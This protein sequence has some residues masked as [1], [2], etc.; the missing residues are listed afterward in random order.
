MKKNSVNSKYSSEA[1]FLRNYD[2]N[3]FS[4]PSAAVDNVIYTIFDGALHVLLVK[5][6]NHPFMDH[7]SLVGG[8]VDLENDFNLES[9][10]KRKLEEK[11]GVK[12]PYLEQFYT[13]GNKDRDPRC[14]SITSVYFALIP[15]ENIKLQVGKGA[16]DIKWAKILKGTIKEKMAFDHSKIIQECTQRLK[17][18]VLYTCQ[19]LLF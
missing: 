10:A 2:P 17:N 3:I 9:T 12:T 5:R 16:K 18:K 6:D 1:E 11:T 19:M 4:R 14:W 13:I 15:V 8:F 7:W